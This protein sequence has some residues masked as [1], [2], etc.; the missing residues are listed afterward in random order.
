[1]VGHR[2]EPVDATRGNTGGSDLRRWSRRTVGDLRAAVAAGEVAKTELQ[3]Y[4]LDWS[5]LED[6]A[7]ETTLADAF[8]RHGAVLETGDLPPDATGDAGKAIP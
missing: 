6:E 1:M 8:A 5:Q 7:D 4:G 2:D 3:L